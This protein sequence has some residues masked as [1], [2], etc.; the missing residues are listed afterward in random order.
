[1]TIIM[2]KYYL[3]F[4]ACLLISLEGSFQIVI[5]RNKIMREMSFHVASCYCQFYHN[6]IEL[7]NFAVLNRL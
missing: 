5:K 1:M 6:V 3:F 4:R 2:S 7:N